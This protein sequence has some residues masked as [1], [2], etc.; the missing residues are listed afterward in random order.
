MNISYIIPLY[1]E[2]T[3]ICLCLASIMAQ[4]HPCDEIIVIDNGSKDSSLGKISSFKEIKILIKPEVTIAAVR[5]AGAEIANGDILAFIDADC[6]LSPDWREHVN[7]V[8]SDLTVSATGAKVDIPD[9]AV[10]IEKAWYSQRNTKCSHVSYINSGNLVIRKCIFDEVG[11]FSENLKT[12]EDTELGWRINKA[13][14]KIL[15]NPLIRSIHLGNPKSLRSFYKKEK[16][17]A[18]GMM[19]TFK[20]SRFDKPFIM[21]VIFLACNLLAIFLLQFFLIRRDFNYGV[22]LFLALIVCVPLVTAIYRSIQF[23]CIR[24]LIQL[25]FLYWVYFIARANILFSIVYNKLRAQ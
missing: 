7:K 18:L 10:W 23:N 3:T 2:E 19:G 24:Y 12:G 9:D 4:L 15:S 8:L 16:W 6:V 22:Y 5:N 1:N 14:Y 11:G 25:I 20:I 21:T 13:G 17:H